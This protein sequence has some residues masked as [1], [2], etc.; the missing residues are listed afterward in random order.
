MLDHDAALELFALVIE[1]GPVL[2][3]PAARHTYM[4]CLGDDG[5]RRG[6]LGPVIFAGHG[7][8][9]ETGCRA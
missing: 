6:Y 9:F 4:F 3:P 2:K 8:V 1:D 5:E 7:V